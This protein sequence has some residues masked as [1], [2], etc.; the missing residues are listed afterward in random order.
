MV[1]RT[2]TESTRLIASTDDAVGAGHLS[3]AV[4]YVKLALALEEAHPT[5]HNRVQRCHFLVCA[6]ELSARTSHLGD[7]DSTLAHAKGDVERIGHLVERAVA[8]ASWHLGPTHVF[9]VD[10]YMAA[11]DVW[12]D[13]CLGVLKETFGRKSA[14]FVEE[15][16]TQAWL[17][18]QVG[19]PDE[20]P[21]LYEE[22][23]RLDETPALSS[24]VTSPA[25][26]DAGAA[27]D[28]HDCAPALCVEASTNVVASLRLLGECASAVDDT[29]RAIEYLTA[30]WAWVKDHATAEDDTV[31]AIQ[32]ITRRLVGLHR[33]VLSLDDTQVVD[34]V[35]R[36]AIEVPD[37]EMA[38][39]AGQLFVHVP[40]E[41]FHS[42]L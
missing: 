23:L 36:R 18:D 24:L 16:R 2:T 14:L 38:F 41:Y 20:A 32:D 10:I 3:D 25:L 33:R 27:T 1:L 11:R 30:A 28:V 15:Q 37:D 8:I 9:L 39:V 12:C 21:S 34:D 19:A 4:A 17:V 40:G 35:R 29:Y 5:D 22:C 31:E 7:A 26:V 13:A 6:A 42:V